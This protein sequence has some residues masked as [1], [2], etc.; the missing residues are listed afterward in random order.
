MGLIRRIRV[1]KGGKG[2]EWYYDVVSPI[3][4]VILYA[5]AK[6]R[7]SEGYGRGK[8]DLD[9]PVYRELQFSIGEML[10]EYHDAELG[11]TPQGDI[12]VVLLKKG[13][14][15][16]A[17]EVKNKFSEEE[18]KRAIQRI[19]DFGIPR[20]GLIGVKERPSVE[21]EET[22]GPEELVKIALELRKRWKEQ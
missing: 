3:L 11:Y 22:L 12:D 6:Y 20:V 15:L 2:V 7:V 9:Y 4:S 17:Y 16:I 10:A 19:K 21:A 14:P 8:A 13:K 18:A 5:E 1:Y